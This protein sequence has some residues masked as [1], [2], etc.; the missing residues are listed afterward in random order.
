[1]LACPTRGP[2]LP[3]PA[4]PSPAQPSS[5]GSFSLSCPDTIL[6][7]ATFSK[8]HHPPLATVSR[9][10]K[11]WPGQPRALL[12]S[13]FCLTANSNKA[14]AG[15]AA[16]LPRAALLPLLLLFSQAW[17]GSCWFFMTL[18]ETLSSL[19]TCPPQ[20]GL[21]LT[22]F[23]VALPES[24]GP[25]LPPSLPPKAGFVPGSDKAMAPAAACTG[26]LDSAILFPD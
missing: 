24:G 21:A 3:S 16:P 20:P 25:A 5:T 18:T 15:P 14:W 1:V 8:Q 19:H 12:P 26:F 22:Q 13:C 2:L 6:P 10:H 17:A 11:L 7:L 4:Q 9:L 23:G